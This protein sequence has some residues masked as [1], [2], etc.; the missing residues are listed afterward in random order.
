[1]SALQTTYFFTEFL[2]KSFQQ[3]LVVAGGTDR[4]GTELIY[5]S[6]V[7]MLIPGAAAWTPIASL[8]KPLKGPRASIVGDK[9]RLSGGRERKGT[10]LE[11]VK[12]D[13]VRDE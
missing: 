9:I 7:R 4:R 1:M 3:A 6:S 11:E 5:L 10:I 12:H 8:P 2:H 13:N